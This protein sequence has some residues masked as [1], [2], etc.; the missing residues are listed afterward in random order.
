MIDENTSVGTFPAHII[1]NE[2]L[3]LVDFCLLRA[4]C[5][6]LDTGIIIRFRVGKLQFKR[7]IGLADKVCKTTLRLRLKSV[8]REGGF[9]GIAGFEVSYS[10]SQCFEFG[11]CEIGWVSR[12]LLLLRN[13]DRSRSGNGYLEDTRLFGYTS[14]RRLCDGF[15]CDLFGRLFI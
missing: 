3:V 5:T 10:F 6:K 7:A 8:F 12:G 11:A 14:S 9:V 2:L 15:S 13:R 4:A 1:T